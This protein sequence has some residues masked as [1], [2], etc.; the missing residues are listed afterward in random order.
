[1]NS[2]FVNLKIKDFGVCVIICGFPCQFYACAKKQVF[3]YVTR[4][5]DFSMFTSNYPNR[6]CFTKM[7]QDIEAS[8]DLSQIS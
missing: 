7:C 2:V 3:S 5:L 4:H 8:S 6:V 1:M